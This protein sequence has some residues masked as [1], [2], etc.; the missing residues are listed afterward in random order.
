MLV[1]AQIAKFKFR[2]YQ[3]R[4][5]SQNSML[6]NSPVYTY[7]LNCVKFVTSQARAAISMVRE[8]LHLA[9]V[10]RNCTGQSTRRLV[11]CACALSVNVATVTMEPSAMI[12]LFHCTLRII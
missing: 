3:V 10:R 6:I 2:Q 12:L 11:K 9:L 4:V 1:S 7:H 8:C 5:I